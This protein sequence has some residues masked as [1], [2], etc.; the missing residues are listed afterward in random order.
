MT[1]AAAM[2]HLRRV[3]ARKEKAAGQPQFRVVFTARD[4]HWWETNY[5][6]LMS[7]KV[8]ESRYVPS[9]QAPVP[10]PPPVKHLCMDCQE[11]ITG[12]EHHQKRK[13]CEPCQEKF[14]G[15][16]FAR[17]RKTRL[18]KAYRAVLKRKVPRFCAC[19]T[20]IRDR[21]GAAFRCRECSA[22]TRSYGLGALDDI[23]PKD[24]ER[25][26]H[27]ILKQIE[28]IFTKAKGERR[29]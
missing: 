9:R 18:Q 27:R 21:H 14:L 4:Y 26:E 11:D 13:R 17:E 16:S 25:P 7:P 24:A 28:G 12:L 20:D 29:P 15:S 22:L 1:E 3:R 5:E 10:A 8:R 19:G 6:Q 23:T 2:Q